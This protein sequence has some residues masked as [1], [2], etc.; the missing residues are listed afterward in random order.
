MSIWPSSPMACVPIDA[1][2][3]VQTQS[4]RHGFIATLLRIPHLVVAVNK[5]D[6]VD[7]D[8][9]VYNRIVDEYTDFIAKLNSQ[10]VTFIPVSAL[11]GDN[12]VEKSAHMPWYEGPALLHH[13][14]HVNVGAS[15]NFVDFRFPVQ[16]VLRPH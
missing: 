16:Y 9:A 1:R 11:A 15:R 14:E 6:L 3:G 10:D 13:L 12:V 2:K 7:Y 8:E 5:M 4:K